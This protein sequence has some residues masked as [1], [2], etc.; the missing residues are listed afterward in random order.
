MLIKSDLTNL[1]NVKLRL[2]FGLGISLT[3]L[4]LRT[5]DLCRVFTNSADKFSGGKLDLVPVRSLRL[6]LDLLL[7]L[8][9]LALNSSSFVG[10]GERDLIYDGRYFALIL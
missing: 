4:G 3:T 7:P 2:S 10:D 9:M 5:G 8:R 6:S 1:S